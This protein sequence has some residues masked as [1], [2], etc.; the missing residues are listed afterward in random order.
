MP[1]AAS[2]GPSIVEDDE[3]AGASIEEVD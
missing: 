2:D 3:P 1:A